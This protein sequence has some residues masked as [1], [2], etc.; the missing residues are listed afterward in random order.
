MGTLQELQPRASANQRRAGSAANGRRCQRPGPPPRLEPVGLTLRALAPRPGIG[1][2]PEAGRFFL[3]CFLF[4][5]H[6][7]GTRLGRAAPP[8]SGRLPAIVLWPRSSL[9]GVCLTAATPSAVQM[10]GQSG[11]C[12]PARRGD[13]THLLDSTHPLRPSKVF[14]GS[15]TRVWP[16]A[17]A[18]AGRPEGQPGNKT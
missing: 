16:A 18:Q 6:C 17:G 8:V 15:S 7:P 12:G 9:F 2:V 1:R 5:N 3:F 10:P 14:A 11:N 13:G 4:F